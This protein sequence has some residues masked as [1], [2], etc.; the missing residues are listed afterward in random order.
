MYMLFSSSPQD[1]ATF[2]VLIYMMWHVKLRSSLVIVD[3]TYI[4]IAG[5]EMIRVYCRMLL[6]W[7]AG[8]MIIPKLQ[9]ENNVDIS[10]P[11]PQRPLSRKVCSYPACWKKLHLRLSPCIIESII[12]ACRVYVRH[13]Q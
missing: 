11:N 2:K 9:L 3:V 6:A 12:F 5:I 7:V 4:S 13:Q 8:D 10:V 1:A